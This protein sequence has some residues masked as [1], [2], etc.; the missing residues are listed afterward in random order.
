[1]DRKLR[2]DERIHWFQFLWSSE[3]RSRDKCT[4]CFSRGITRAES[5]DK[6]TG[7]WEPLSLPHSG[8]FFSCSISLRPRGNIVSLGDSGKRKRAD[9]IRFQMAECGKRRGKGPSYTL[10]PRNDW[11]PPNCAKLC[12]RYCTHGRHISPRLLRHATFSMSQETG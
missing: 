12:G 5:Q 2:R 1:M 3:R 8:H 9:V 10:C 4:S 6:Q 7:L 11:T